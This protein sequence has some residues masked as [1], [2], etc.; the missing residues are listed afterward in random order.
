MSTLKSTI[1]R[2]FDEV[3][4]EE[5]LFAEGTEAIFVPMLRQDNR[6]EM[7]ILENLILHKAE[8]LKISPF[9]VRCA[10]ECRFNVEGL[11]DLPERLFLQALV[12]L[13]EFEGFN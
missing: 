12:H 5:R 9:S 11:G 1:R 3:A 2:T 7:I 8:Q 6:R 10:L 13:V 4:E